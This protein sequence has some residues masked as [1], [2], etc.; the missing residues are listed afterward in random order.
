MKHLFFTLYL[1]AGLSSVTFAQ[2]DDK[3]KLDNLKYYLSSI[4]DNVQSMRYYTD[5]VKIVGLLDQIDVLASSLEV[6]LNNIILPEP[7]N[8]PINEPEP[9]E[10]AKIENL[11]DYSWKGDTINEENEDDNQRGMGISKFMPFKNKFNTSFEIQFGINSL[12][13]GNDAP[14]GV[15]TP[16]INTGGSWYWDFA[17]MRRARLGGKSSKIA[18]NYGISYLKNRFKIENDIRLTNI[19]G[20]PFFTPISDVKENPKLNI[21]YINIPLSLSFQLSKKMTLQLGGYIG[22]RVHTVQKFELKPPGEKIEEQRYAG[23]ALNNWIY[24]GTVSIGIGSFDLIGR[25]N[26]S[27][28][29]KDNPNYDYNTFMIGTSISLF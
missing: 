17:L 4:K 23:Y 19:D 8:M 15:L 27:K 5:S 28:L 29:F 18:L 16:D 26:I 6:E 10:P 11:D 3:M 20:T 9:M 21:G 24:G 12:M 13:Q 7:E 2:E 22:Y 14:S 1:M 25:Y